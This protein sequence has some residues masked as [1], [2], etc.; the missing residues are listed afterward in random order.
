MWITVRNSSSTSCKHDVCRQLRSSRQHQQ[1][2]VQHSV[3][4]TQ[5]L[6]HLGPPGFSS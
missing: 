1:G 5:T 3:R 2:I 4:S 6:L